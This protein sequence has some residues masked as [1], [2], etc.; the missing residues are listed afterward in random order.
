MADARGL[1]KTAAP[2][3]AA[4]PGRGRQDGPARPL[5]GSAR[6]DGPD[7]RCARF[8]GVDDLRPIGRSARSRTFRGVCARGSFTGF[9]CVYK[10]IEGPPEY[11]DHLVRMLEA[12]ARAQADAGGRAR[13]AVSGLPRLFAFDVVTLPGAAPVL[14][15]VRSWLEG[16]TLS[17]IYLDS[18]S[19]TS[20]LGLGEALALLAGS[21]RALADA[22]ACLG[23]R[24]LVH[25]DVKPSNIV[26]L[27]SEDAARSRA[28]ARAAE[29]AARGVP[30]ALIDLDLAFAVEPDGTCRYRPRTQGT[31]GYTA[32]SDPAPPSCAQAGDIYALGATAHVFLTGYL[33]AAPGDGGL[34]RA[35]PWCPAPASLREPGEL[36]PADVAALLRDCLSPHPSRRPHAAALADAFSR[37]AVAHRGEPLVRD[38][39]AGALDDAPTA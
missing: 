9:S 32:P 37:L 39:R 5:P 7:P 21:A 31:P 27:S 38:L 22:S 29:G 33:P 14:Y 4:R 30:C 23:D 34:P 25:Q 10:E 18:L 8:A 16:R 24:L 15:S 3:P 11:L 12:L 13:G 26:V 1:G 17:G 20:R 36:L 19:P 28:S 2:A 6:I 35:A